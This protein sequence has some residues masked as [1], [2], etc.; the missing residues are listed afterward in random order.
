MRNK[1][2]SAL[3]FTVLLL[4][5]LPV[6]AVFA[7]SVHLKGSKNAKPSFTDLGLSLNAQSELSGPEYLIDKIYH[8]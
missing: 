1:K 6:S 7:S 5:A 3:L 8:V 2:I 4:L